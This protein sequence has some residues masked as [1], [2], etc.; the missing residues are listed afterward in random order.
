M[1][2]ATFGVAAGIHDLRQ[3]DEMRRNDLVA[4]DVRVAQLYLE[5]VAQRR[6]HV[7]EE[8]HLFPLRVVTLDRRRLALLSAQP[9]HATVTLLLFI[10]LITVIV[11]FTTNRLFYII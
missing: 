2:Y 6:K 7:R 3:L 5:T 10:F 11:N 4:G 8:Q 9:H 1:I